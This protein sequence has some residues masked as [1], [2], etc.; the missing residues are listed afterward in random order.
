MNQQTLQRLKY[1][2]TQTLTESVSLSAKAL[3]TPNFAAAKLILCCNCCFFMN[4][5]SQRSFTYLFIF[6][7]HFTS[8]HLRLQ[9]KSLDKPVTFFFVCF[10]MSRF[11]QT[12]APDTSLKKKTTFLSCNELQMDTLNSNQRERRGRQKVLMQVHLPECLPA[13]DPL[14]SLLVDELTGG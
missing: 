12:S 8:C 5:K 2:C 7:I 1:V 9:L 10:A 6:A 11:C 14:F 3:R 13:V 4:D